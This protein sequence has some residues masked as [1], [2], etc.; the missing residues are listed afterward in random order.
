VITTAGGEAD[1]GLQAIR[2]PRPL[3][4]R[5]REQQLTQRQRALLDELEHVIADGFSHWTMAELAAR[6]GCSLRTLYALAPSRDELVLIVVDRKLWRV[7]RAA[8]EAI[9]AKVDPLDAVRLYL[10]TATE[11]VSGWSPAFARDLVEVP[12]AHRLSNEHGQHLFEVTRT[13]LDLAVE[14]G[15]VE[16]IDTTAVARVLSGLGRYFTSPDVMATLRTTPKAAADQVVNL[17]LRGLRPPAFR[18]A[19]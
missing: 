15:H 6:L 10:E 5:R 14:Q 7:G 3:L 1:R 16:D 11:A 12:A 17:I 4:P 19:P 18:G 9:A 13:L 2:R 8:R